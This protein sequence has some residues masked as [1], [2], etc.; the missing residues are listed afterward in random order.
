M[1]KVSEDTPAA[2]EPV[3]A[4]ILRYSER[5]AERSQKIAEQVHIKLIPVMRQEEPDPP[6]KATTDTRGWPPL[7]EELKGN[8]SKVTEALDR[9]DYVLSQTEL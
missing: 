2:K 7:F 4:E 8:F 6:L 3:S 5:L 1:Y 9:I